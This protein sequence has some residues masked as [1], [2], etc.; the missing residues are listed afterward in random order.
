MGSSGVCLGHYLQ[1]EDS[2]FLVPSSLIWEVNDPMP[3]LDKS[4]VQLLHLVSADTV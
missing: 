1:V 4:H 3:Q 2:L